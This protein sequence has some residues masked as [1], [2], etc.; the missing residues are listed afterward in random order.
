MKY[1]KNTA[2]LAVIGLAAAVGTTGVYVAVNHAGTAAGPVDEEEKGQEQDLKGTTGKLMEDT[3]ADRPVSQDPTVTKE[4][5]VYVTANADGSVREIS[6]S[7]RLKNAGSTNG[8][9]LDRT[10]LTGIQNLKG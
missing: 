8:A 4:E 10:D 3:E 1:K 6:V 7:D 9:L 5:T 2:K